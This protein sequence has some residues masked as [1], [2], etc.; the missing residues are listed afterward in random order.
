MTDRSPDPELETRVRDDQALRLTDKVS[1][2]A[3][4]LLVR[5]SLHSRKSLPNSA[6]E[7]FTRRALWEQAVIAYAR[8][9]GTGRRERVPD[10]IMRGISSDLLEVHEEVLKWRNTHV[11]HRVE[12]K[13]ERAE[14]T[15]VYS[16]G[17]DDP[18]SVRVRVHL[19]VGPNEESFADD[20]EKL[21]DKIKNAIWE[22]YFPVLELDLLRV[23]A[24]REET[25]RQAE[26]IQDESSSS[27]YVI[28]VNPT[29]RQK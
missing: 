24:E 8:C 2:W 9:F 29:G 14:A 16:A 6:S 21:A 15:V 23:H 18:E 13:F 1:L 3:D 22:Q 25:R 17:S 28:T 27:V 11:A 5:Q 10:H 19:P 4:L 20:F 12:A 7:I 26:P